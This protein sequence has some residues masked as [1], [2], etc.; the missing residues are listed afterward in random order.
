MPQHLLASLSGQTEAHL[1]VEPESGRLMHPL[2][3]PAF[4]ALRE[5]AREEGFDLAVASSFR[6]FDRQRL[7]WNEKAVGLRPVLDDVG[8]VVDLSGLDDLDKVLAILR[9]SALPGASRHHWGSDLDVYDRAALDPGCGPELTVAECEKGGPFHDFHQWLN[10]YLPTTQFYRPYAI[11]RGGVAPEPWHLSY[12]PV[13][14]C[15]EEVMAPDRLRQV[16]TESPIAL[17]DTVLKHL[18]ELYERFIL[19]PKAI[20]GL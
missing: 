2:V 10:D 5:A 9:W 13:A 4:T 18:D 3:I 12:F 19:V 20:D 14:K 16:L 17:G 7:I 1:A 15:Y 11:D 6:D 8:N